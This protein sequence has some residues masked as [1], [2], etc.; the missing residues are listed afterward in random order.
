[1]K[2]RLIFLSLM[3][4]FVQG[5]SIFEPCETAEVIRYD[6]SMENQTSCN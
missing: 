3:L 5:C 4:T 1:M 2:K 6:G